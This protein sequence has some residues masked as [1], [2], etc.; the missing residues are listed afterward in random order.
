[1]IHAYRL[2]GSHII[3][4][5][6]SGSVHRVDPVAFYAITHWPCTEDEL[7]A[8]FPGENLDGLLEDIRALIDRRKLFAPELEVPEPQGQRPLKALCLHV[9]HTCNLACDYCFAQAGRYHGEQA[10]MPYEVGRQA[11]AFLLA[12]S[13]NHHNLEVDFFGGEPLMNWQVVKDLV[14]Y[15]RARESETGK[16]FRFTLTTNGMLLDSETTEFCNQEM[17]N[18]VLSLDGRKQVHD[19]LRR[20]AN[21]TGSYDIVV[22]KFQTFVKERGGRSYYMRGTFT[23]ANPDFSADLYHMADL[24]FHALSMEPVVCAP[25]SP[26]A[27]TGEDLR[28][29]LREY[30]ALALEMA[31]RR[32]TSGAFTF[33]HYQLDLKHGPCIYKRVAGCGS[34]TEYFAVTPQ[35]DLYPCH[36]FAGEAE[37]KLGDVWQGVTRPELCAQFARC[38]LRNKPVC[39]DCWAKYY[40][41]GGCA[42]NAWHACGDINGIYEDGCEMFKKRIECAI[43]LAAL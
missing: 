29:A 5:V 34:G 10:L 7:R 18:V 20:T 43:W 16:R 15:A 33:Y 42:A 22:P 12:N 27:L 19:R 14:A 11:L 28:M 4:D 17:S 39:R 2:H 6:N 25:G 24:G 30:E 23:H 40:C 26:H 9:A 38:T 3:L 31:R 21:G 36:Q 1:M 13:G 32:G 41:A 35:G 8:A 37:W